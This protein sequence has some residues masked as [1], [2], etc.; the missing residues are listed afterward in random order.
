[1]NRKLMPS[2]FETKIRRNSNVEED[3][4]DLFSSRPSTMGGRI[5][6]WDKTSKGK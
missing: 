2:R 6:Y 3:K 5:H 1:M 4:E